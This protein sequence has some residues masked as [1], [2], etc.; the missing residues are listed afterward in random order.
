MRLFAPFSGLVT[1]LSINGNIDFNA[2][3]ISNINLLYA[4]KAYFGSETV[5]G[6]LYGP[7]NSA[8][9]LY[10]QSCGASG[11]AEVG[12]L[13][14]GKLYLS[15]TFLQT[16]LDGNSQEIQNLADLQFNAS[17]GIKTAVGQTYEAQLIGHNGSIYVVVADIYNAPTPL[18]RIKYGQLTGQL[19]ANGQQ[20]INKYWDHGSDLLVALDVERTTQ[21]ITYVM[22]KQLTIG[23]N[24]HLKIKLQ[25]KTDNA[26]HMASIEIFKNEESWAGPFNTTSLTYVDKEQETHN[27]L[28][29]DIMYIKGK[30][31]DVSAT[32]YLQNFR[33]YYEA[34][35]PQHIIYQ[36]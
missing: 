24:C 21:S 33:L 16:V 5:D 34:F 27:W 19:D 15:N 25:M 17:C 23:V 29:S 30:I 12:K 1:D 9:N 7:N 36:D 11:Y 4:I 2:K 6:Y 31:A 28:A 20:I 3:N 18:F 32:C 14:N 26:S 10:I 8:L 13:Y 35:K 22:L